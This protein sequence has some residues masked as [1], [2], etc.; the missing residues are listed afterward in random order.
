VEI[1]KQIR[2]DAFLVIMS[3]DEIRAFQESN[4]DLADTQAQIAEFLLPHV[5]TIGVR[6]FG[7]L[8][9]LCNNHPAKA[10][11]NSD[12]AKNES[13]QKIINAIKGSDR[14]FLL[15]LHGIGPKSADIL[16]SLKNG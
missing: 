2:E 7:R 13:S 5:D 6:M 16:L 9:R 10:G 4:G 8:I 1:L 14:K 11:K 15:S 3:F 12:W